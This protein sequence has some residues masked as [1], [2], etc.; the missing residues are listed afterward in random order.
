M[1]ESRA[2]GSG[3]TGRWALLL[4]VG[5]VVAPTQSGCGSN[6]VKSNFQEEL[7]ASNAGDNVWE[8]GGWGRGGLSLAEYV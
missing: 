5:E 4:E 8:A 1:G 6:K 7:K 3:D 2:G